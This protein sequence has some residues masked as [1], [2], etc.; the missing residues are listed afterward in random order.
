MVFF[1]QLVVRKQSFLSLSLLPVIKVENAYYGLSIKYAG[2][3]SIVVMI[4]A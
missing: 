3:M 1:T 4:V 2:D